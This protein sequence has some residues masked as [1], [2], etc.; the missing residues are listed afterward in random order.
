MKDY[1][2]TTSTGDSFSQLAN[3]GDG[4]T[5]KTVSDDA[6]LDASDSGKLIVLDADEGAEITL[7]DVAEG[8]KYKFVVGSAFAT[9]DW[10]IVAESAV[11]QGTVIVNGAS[12]LGENE[13]TITFDAGSEKVGDW[14][15]VESDG[16]NWYITG[17]GS[18][19]GSITLTAS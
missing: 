13:D 11:I 5:V 12:V 9:T 8:L 19:A 4:V 17:I 10:T 3:S 18:G 6:T 2:K 16:T 7:P 1:Q 15:L 14:V